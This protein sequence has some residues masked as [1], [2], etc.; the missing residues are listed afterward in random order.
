MTK[1]IKI[2][3]A[4]YFVCVASTAA[5][6][7]DVYEFTS[8][9]KRQDYLSLTKELRCP[10]C[11]NQD[12]ADSNAPIAADMR[13][14]VHRLLEE[15][16]KPEEIINFMIERFGDFVTYKPKQS[17]E[18]FLLWYGPWIFIGIGA[19]FIILAVKSRDKGA[20]TARKEAAST[21]N[22]AP[23]E[24]TSKTH[25]KVNALLAE[26]DNDNEQGKS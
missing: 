9:D 10:K 22:N 12:I 15:G 2:I 20:G 25:N 23:S 3:A 19:V 21:P 1:T 5:A 18:T 13:R 7:I 4:L 8:E 17:P 14:E 16:N 11:Q 24:K 6:N 26:Y